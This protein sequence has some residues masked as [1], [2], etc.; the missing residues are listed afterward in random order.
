MAC[1][2]KRARKRLQRTTHDL[3]YGKY[4]HHKRQQRQGARFCNETSG[5]KGQERN[6]KRDDTTQGIEGAK[7]KERLGV[8]H[9]NARGVA[10]TT[11][12]RLSKHKGKVDD[13]RKTSVV[14]GCVNAPV[15]PNAR[16]RSHGARAGKLIGKPSLTGI[17][18]RAGKDANPKRDIE[19]R[20][21]PW[22]AAQTQKP[23]QRCLSPL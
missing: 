19:H 2:L 11:P 3:D 9:A 5:G 7:G 13:N 16:K 1:S 20:T 10:N 4:R 18:R 23:P 21:P 6:R 17:N 8:P 22:A 14:K 12:E 15:E